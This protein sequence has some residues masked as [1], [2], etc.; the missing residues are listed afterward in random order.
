M[1]DA[2]RFDAADQGGIVCLGTTRSK[3]NFGWAGMDKFSH[4]FP[5]LLNGRTYLPAVAMY[6]GRIAKLSTHK[7]QHCLDHAIVHRGGGG[8]VEV[9]VLHRMHL[10]EVKT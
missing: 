3:E 1:A 8:I 2:V 6:R 10:G 7:W 4:F 9:Y 5:C